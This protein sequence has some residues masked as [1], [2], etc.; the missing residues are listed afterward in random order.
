VIGRARLQIGARNAKRIGIL[1]HRRDE[2]LGQRLDRLT[3]LDRAADDLVVDVR[4]VAHISH[5]KSE[6]AQPALDDVEHHHHACVSYV[7]VVVHSHPADI[8]PYFACTTRH[9]RLLVTRERVVDA[10]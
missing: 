5:A 6:C 7:T 4:N 10:Q 2:A 1:M 9:E 3:V 8:H